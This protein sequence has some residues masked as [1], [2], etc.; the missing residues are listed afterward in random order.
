MAGKGSI[1]DSFT[2]V[3]G[4]NTEG[5]FF[6]TPENSWTE[7]VN[8]VPNTDG[9]FQR[10]NGID[11]E[12]FYTLYAA[13]ITADQKALWAFGV[14]A[15]TTVAG[16][17]N[18]DFFV[19]QTG[20]LLHFYDGVSGSISA[21]KKPFTVDL[22][23]YRAFNNTSIDG[24]AVASFASTY[25]KLIVTTQDSDPILITYNTSSNTITVTK[26]TLEIR[27]FI[28]F[29]SPVD[30]DVEKTEAEW[31]SLGFL[32]QA[33]YNLYNQGWTDTLINSYKSANGTKLPSNSKQWIF[34]K[35]SSD[36]F[37]AT[38]LNKNDFGSSPAP[39]G[40]FILE[41]F[42]QDRSSIVTST[43][44]RP[45]VCAFF[46]GRVWY[47]GVSFD[48][49]LGTVYFSQVL[50]TL[51]KVGNCYQTNDP[52]S[53]V[54]SDL[55]DSDG[56]TIQIPEAGE[57][58]AIHPLGRGVVVLATNGV[59]LISGLDTGFSASNYTVERITSVGSNSTKSVV[60]VEDTVV[61]WS[62]NGIYVLKVGV[63]G[64][65]ITASNFS[66]QNIKTFY[67][68]IPV[69]NK[70]YA[71]GAYSATDKVIYWLYSNEP[72]TDTSGGKYNKNAVLAYDARLSS[73]YWFEF[74][75]SLGVVPVSLETTKETSVSE[76]TYSI[77]AGVDDVLV[78]ADTVIAPLEVVNG[79]RKLFKF[80]VLHPITTNNYSITFA[81]IENLRPAS[82]KFK[83]WYVFDGAGAEKSA[84]V[85][86]GYQLADAGPARMKTGQ[87]LTTFM[88]RTE[89]TFDV[90]ANPVNES[91]CIMQSRWDFTDSSFANKWAAEQQIYRQQRL[92]L[93]EPG[94]TF[95]DG[96]PIVISKNKLRGR[97][98]AVQFKF[99]SQ[100]GKDMQ[101]VG[102][103]GTFIG[104]T[105]V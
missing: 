95:D 44:Y 22:R 79:T 68:D 47:A 75:N 5:G 63:S 72:L 76:I 94:T 33:K 42:K 34:G 49:Q 18:V 103:S 9:S 101:V 27:D 67:N 52:T 97:G 96:Y 60:A 37:S 13:N 81:D 65:D 88:K 43:P 11:Y 10:R 80:L 100:E 53:E 62:T 2:F 26:I 83:D 39:K 23:T 29:E 54:I 69:V 16:D 50:S 51:D 78:G 84:Y 104:N 28:G 92:F 48:Q 105:N 74:N 55:V 21:T 15:W 58:N 56:G 8:V 45:K 91:G 12:D 17:G 4:L 102:W 41:A 20:Y 59:W 1:K 70:L 86:T 87:Y 7:G 35:D 57:I 82:T 93:A 32:T 71:E 36:N 89:T 98:R 38:A 99:T 40:R 25:G 64:I 14:G 61:Y 90:N 66:D 46:A 3:G 73:W 85:L 77:V 6:V 31:T 24:T 30:V 19:V